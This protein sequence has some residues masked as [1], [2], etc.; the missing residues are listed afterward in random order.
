MYRLPLVLVVRLASGS[1]LGATVS[2]TFSNPNAA[3]APK[4]KKK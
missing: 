2:T 4:G 3:P 1:A